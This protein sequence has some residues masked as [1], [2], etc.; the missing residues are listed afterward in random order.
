MVSLMTSMI[1]ISMRVS[2]TALRDDH[3]EDWV[4][5]NLDEDVN[6]YGDRTDEDGLGNYYLWLR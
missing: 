2:M 3:L 4:E 1:I 6:G 5:K